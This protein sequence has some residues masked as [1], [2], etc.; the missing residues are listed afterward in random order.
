MSDKETNLKEKLRQA[1]TSTIKVISDDFEI[2]HNNKNNKNKPNVFELE[3]L[4][5]KIDFVKAR[6]EADSSALKKKFSDDEIYKKNL[7]TNSSCKSLYAIAEKIRYE[8]LGGQ[9]LKGIEKNLKDNYGHLMNIKRKDQLRTKEDV[10]IAEAFE[11][12][13]LKNFYDINLNSQSLKMLNFWEKEFDQSINKHIGFL[14]ENFEDQNIYSSKFSKILQEMDIFQT[15]N[16]DETEE[17]NQNDGQDNPSN[18]DQES[19]TD[20]KKDENRDQETEANLDSDYDIDEYKLDEQQVDTESD[21]QTSEQ[22][23]Q[24]K[25][26]NNL[27]HDY[28]IFTTKFD[29]IVK[30][31]NLENADEANKL[32]KSLDQ[33]LI[34]FQD[35]VTKLANKLQRQLLAKQNRAWEFDLEEGLLDSSKLPRIIMD[36]Y[37]SLSFK[38]EK[39]LDFKDTIVTLLIDNS[40]SMRGRPITIAAIC[41]DILSRTLERCSV[42]VEILGFTTKNWKGGQSREFWNKQDK[43]KTPGR[44]NDLRHIIYKSADS[45]WRQAKNN[46]GLM[47]KEG[48]LKENIDGEAINWAFSRLRKRKEERK[49]LMVI[50]DG[51]PVDDSTLSVNSGDFLEKHLKK[52]VKFIEE[53]TEIEVLAIGI[54]HDVSRYYDRAIKITDVNEL[55]DVMISQLSSL[56]DTKKKL[57]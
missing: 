11:L 14:K 8:T 44:L 12:Y 50:S 7:P 31:E 49:I 32:R 48:L 55:G 13:M 36:P 30:A 46:L 19:E 5:N 51:A 33:Q 38:K 47:L 3:S 9:M 52:M 43:P 24:K 21:Q 41:A 2:D 20:D 22:V 42:K 35:I 34:G 6:A 57:H 56:F 45:N 39:D 1:L 10:P 53:K 37:N 40:G 26:I 29:E 4:R 17:N 23:I 16:E 27:N 54:G 18:D 15:E 28:K 25:N